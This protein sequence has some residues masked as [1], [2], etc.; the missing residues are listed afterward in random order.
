ME[1]Q[2]YLNSFFSASI[3][4]FVPVFIWG[5]T[6]SHFPWIIE[7]L[8]FSQIRSLEPE[9][10]EAMPSKTLGKIEFLEKLSPDQARSLSPELFRKTGLEVSR[11]QHEWGHS[12]GNDPLANP[13]EHGHNY[14]HA[15]LVKVGSG[16]HEHDH[17]NLDNTYAPIHNDG[18]HPFG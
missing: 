16:G 7:K 14:S 8:D 2:L 6:V 9:A 17:L 13:V 5:N 18:T 1:K 11:H 12:H 4:I 3:S 15:H 10:L